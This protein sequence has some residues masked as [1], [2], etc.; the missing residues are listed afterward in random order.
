MARLVDDLLLLARLDQ[1]R[2]IERKPVELVSLL[3][4]AIQDLHAIDPTRPVTE[5]FPA[6]AT[7]VG[8]RVRLRQIVDNLLSNA[9]AHTPAGTPIHVAVTPTASAVT[10]SVADKGPG[11]SEADQAKIFER[12]FRADPSRARS[13]GGTGL[14]LSIVASLVEAHGGT[15]SVDSVVGMGTSFAIALPVA[16]PDAA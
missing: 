16:G 11:I 2:G 14:G 6:E 10:V 7:V 13:K 15:V 3:R 12:F 5:A 8:D 1:Q 4:E 9:R